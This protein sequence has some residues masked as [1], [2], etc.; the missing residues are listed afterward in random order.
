MQLLPTALHETNL[1]EI[2]KTAWEIAEM[3]F[4]KIGKLN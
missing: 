2:N 3:G 4:A 1:S